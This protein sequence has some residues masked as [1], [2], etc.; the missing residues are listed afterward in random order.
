MKT[1]NSKTSVAESS[2]AKSPAFDMTT[3]TPDLSVEAL[4]IIIQE[5]LKLKKAKSS[6]K[7]AINQG[8]GAF[9]KNL[10]LEGH[11]NKDILKM[12]HEHYGNE[13]TTYQCVAWYRNDM[14]NKGII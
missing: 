12:V 14:K 9:V 7:Q 1:Q 10:I 2:E 5:C 8:V 6:T 3:L 11:A 13:N 4:N